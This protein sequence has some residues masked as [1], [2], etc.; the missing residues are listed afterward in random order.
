[1]KEGDLS[2]L[3]EKLGSQNAILSLQRSKRDV[4]DNDSA[5]RMLAAFEKV[6]LSGKGEHGA[7]F[8]TQTIQGLGEGGGDNQM[9]FKYEAAK[10]PRPDLAGDPAALRRFVRFNSD[11]PKYQAE[12]FKFAKR[13]SGGSQMAM[14]DILYSMFDPK[15]EK[16]MDIYGDLMNNKDG[17]MD[18]LSGKIDPDKRRKATLNREQMY[19]DATNDVG[20][21]QQVTKD[22]SNG[23][24]DLLI[25]M[26]SIVTTL[27]KG[28]KVINWPTWITGNKTK[29]GK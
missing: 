1:M 6:G 25:E 28:I 19:Q 20:A 7:D 9:L 8:L 29:S 15:S 13:A 22:F 23:M 12:F 16:D 26:K 17:S 10:R 2:T 24:Q 27:D 21:V 18:M 14:D 5:L 3:A 11:D 4:V